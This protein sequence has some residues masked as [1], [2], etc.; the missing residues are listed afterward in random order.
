MLI[1][2]VLILFSPGDDE[3]EVG[4]EDE[5]ADEDDGNEGEDGGDE[6]E[7]DVDLTMYL[8]VVDGVRV[9]DSSGI[10]AICGGGRL[11]GSLDE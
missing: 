4:D 11:E 2:T 8:L 1:V 9:D 10:S 3:D 5:D 7:D 6:D